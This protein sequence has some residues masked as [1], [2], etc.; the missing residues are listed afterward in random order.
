MAKRILVLTLPH[1]NLLD[2]SGPVQAFATATHLGGHYDISYVSSRTAVESAQRLELSGLDTLGPVQPGD[3]VLIPGA[4]LSVSLDLD[5]AVIDWVHEASRAGAEFASVCTGAFVLAEAGLLDGHRCTSHWSVI[6]EMRS[7]HPRARVVDDVLFV[8]DGSIHTSAG[9][10]SGI[11]LA[12][13]LIERDHG[14]SLAARVA[15]EMVVYLRRNGASAPRSPF[16]E[17]RDHTDPYVHSV[18]QILSDGFA[19]HFTLDEL[20]RAVHV[21]PRTLTTRFVRTIGMTPLQYQQTLRLG[22]A[23]SLLSSTDLSIEEVSLSCGFADARQLR[24]LFVQAHGL[25]P[26]A[27]RESASR[28]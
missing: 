8:M 4:D 24:R 17:L 19:N 25:S 11:D 26:R 14:S 22:H 21:S 5:P 15:R 6:D 2:L 3:L 20:S 27:Y 16:V 18:Q 28:P 12:L 9:I 7:R 13:A 23:K 1:V 10:A